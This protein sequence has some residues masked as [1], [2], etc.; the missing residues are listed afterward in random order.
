MAN[1]V[2]VTSQAVI[3]AHPSRPI[4]DVQGQQIG[5]DEGTQ[6]EIAGTVNGKGPFSVAIWTEVYTQTQA[7]GYTG[8]TWPEIVAAFLVAAADPPSQDL[9]TASL[10]GQTISA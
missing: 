5:T 9:G 6:Y 1:T 3:Q 4:L 10:V 2:V 8:P 7:P